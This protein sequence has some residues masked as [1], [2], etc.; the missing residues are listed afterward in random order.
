MSKTR[1]KVL[2]IIGLAVV[3]ALSVSIFFTCAGSGSVAEAYESYFAEDADKWEDG[4][5]TEYSTGIYWYA[6]GNPIPR[7]D[8][9]VDKSKPTLIFAHG[10]K[11]NEGYKERDLLSLW[12]GTNSQ[13][14]KAGFGSFEFDDAYYQTL[15]DL[16]Y[17]V[18]HFYWNQLSDDALNC[19]EKIWSSTG[20]VGMGYVVNNG[21][22]KRVQGDASKN[23]TKS[24]AVI[25][26][27]AIKQALGSDYAQ[28]L[29]L[30][31]H[32]MGG[33]LVLATGE[34]LCVQKE[35]GAVSEHLVPSQVTLIDP[36]MTFNA[37]SQGATVDH[38]HGKSYPEREK[39]WIV[40]LCADAMEHL[41]RHN[42]AMD[43]YGTVFYRMYPM[44]L[45]DEAG[46]MMTERLAR[47]C[48]WTYLSSLKSKYTLENGHCMAIDY[49]FSTLYE[50]TIA[51]DNFGV[52]VPSAKASKE[53][54]LSL[55]GKAFTQSL[56]VSGA[57][58]FYMHNSAYTRTNAEY[59]EVGEDY[60][61]YREPP[62][63]AP[64]TPDGE[65]SGN[66]T[67]DIVSST[68]F[69][70]GMSVGGAIIV[71]GIVGIIVIV[72]KNKKA[73]Q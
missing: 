65:P 9:P 71:A 12:H 57:N 59:E 17:N 26:G 22:G 1:S 19:D 31:G 43:S 64:E 70:V 72:L 62:K 44:V 69:I 3:F 60:T 13:F 20:Q 29:H 30:V 27:D 63:G 53:Y 35:E 11:Q 34:Y 7:R 23:P 56:A 67:R 40:G 52:E 45:G 54:I 21:S 42:V 66:K 38:L 73:K 55:R 25:F 48:A 6:S 8:N 49:Y 36:Y 37:L 5:F 24:V 68:G 32:S 50:E 33:Q 51:K 61:A 10:W 28:D 18:G 16:G 4:V 58:P 15:I 39:V 14:E 46:K 41:A 47:Y 2:A